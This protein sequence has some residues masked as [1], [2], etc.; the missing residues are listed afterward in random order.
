MAI[1]TSTHAVPHTRSP[2]A[3]RNGVQRAAQRLLSAAK[4]VLGTVRSIAGDLPDVA[5]WA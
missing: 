2:D 3:T 5:R 4:A 1:A